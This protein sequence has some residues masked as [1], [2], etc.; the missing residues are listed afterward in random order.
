MR[1]HRNP[2]RFTVALGSI[3]VLSGCGG[4]TVFKGSERLEGIPF[5]MKIAQCAQETSVLESKLG[6]TFNVVDVD[7]KGTPKAE[8]TSFPTKGYVLV[9]DTPAIRDDLVDLL[10][11]AIR[12]TEPIEDIGARLSVELRNISNRDVGAANTLPVKNT[13]TSSMVV[14]GAQTYFI[15][16]RP[17]LFGSATGDFK[18]SEDSTLT[19]ATSTVTDDTAKTL[20]GLFP[21][22]DKLKLRWGIVAKPAAPAFINGRPVPTPPPPTANRNWDLTLTEVKTVWVLKKLLP[23]D[24]CRATATAAP[25][26]LADARQGAVQIASRTAVTPSSGDKAAGE[27]S[28]YQIKGTIAPPLPKDPK[29]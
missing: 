22:T 24:A 21:I 16:T 18:F 2:V 28:A 1:N 4:L 23:S 20:L 17:P 5:Y 14:D 19:G 12:S 13:W 27:D 7:A 29:K 6:V 9:P 11:Q 15:N 3:G 10:V 25:L 26:T 8:T